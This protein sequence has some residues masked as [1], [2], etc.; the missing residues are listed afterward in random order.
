[1]VF[2]SQ[3]KVRKC[4]YCENPPK[5]NMT[6][7]RHRG[8]YR[9]CGAEIC[10][11]QQYKD[12]S[13]CARKKRLLIKEDMMCVICGIKFLKL[14]ANHKR[15]C[16][17]C[18]PDKGW[19]GRA[20]LY[21]IGKKQWDNMLHNQNNKCALCDKNPE[22]VDH[23]HKEERVRGLLCGACNM[24]IARMDRD[25]EWLIRAMKYIGIKNA[26]ISF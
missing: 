26:T 17:E 10:L 21:G 3:N 13:V 25:K 23:C 8:Y 12:N 22:T 5:I 19:R 16:K 14:S 1:M 4:K 20:N 6:G 7:G 18:V 11:K 15:Y 24:Y 9:T 2:K